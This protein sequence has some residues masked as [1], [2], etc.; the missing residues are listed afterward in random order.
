MK[1]LLLVKAGIK[2]WFAP[3]WRGLT[4]LFAPCVA[5]AVLYAIG[6]A[7]Q[8]SYLQSENVLFSVMIPSFCLA[9]VLLIP[10]LQEDEQNGGLRAVAALP[11]SGVIPY[12]SVIASGF[13]LFVCQAVLLFLFALFLGMPVAFPAP[14]LAAAIL[15]MAFARACMA[16]AGAILL[17][18][19]VLRRTYSLIILVLSLAL[20]GAVVYEG[21]FSSA[22]AGVWRWLP[23][24][25]EKSLFA[26]L[27]AKSAAF[28]DWLR[29]GVYWALSFLLSLSFFPRFAGHAR[30][31]P[32]KSK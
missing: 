29:P 14:G 18:P 16:C 30:K 11:V 5:F 20:S 28:S 4:A 3:P 27:H 26:A 25:A 2:G 7:S 24:G 12:L 21:L 17:V 23:Y 19:A 15:L 10:G 13:A 31:K 22:A 6:N 9:E 1:F 8:A 32:Q